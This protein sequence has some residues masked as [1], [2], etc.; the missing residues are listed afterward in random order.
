MHCLRPL[1]GIFTTAAIALSACSK[2]EPVSTVDPLP[3]PEGMDSKKDLSV[4]A[5][6]R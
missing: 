1:A 2:D 5:G 4:K 6:A 3:M